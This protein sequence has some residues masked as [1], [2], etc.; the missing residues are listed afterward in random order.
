MLKNNNIKVTSEKVEECGT[1]TKKLYVL[2]NNITSSTKDN[3]KPSTTSTTDEELANEF[4][5][6]L[7]NKIEKIRDNVYNWFAM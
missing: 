3:P 5:D 7:I 6:F 2:I 1:Y 4:A